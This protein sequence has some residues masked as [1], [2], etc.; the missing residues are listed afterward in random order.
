M[1]YSGWELNF[2]DNSKNF[3]NYQFFLIKKYLKNNLLEVG[4]GNG[5]MVDKYISKYFPN[6]TST[7]N[8]KNLNKTLVKK[9]KNKK[10]VKIYR[11]KI[12]EFKNKFN[13]II[14]SDVIE[15][16]KD[17]EKEI[18]IALKKLNKN[19]YLIIMVPAFQ[20][21]YSEYDKSIGHFR[22]YEKK[23]FVNF[24]KKNKIK[25]V[26]SI[27]FDSIGYFF[28]VLSKLINTKNKK[29]VGLGAF[30]WNLL[31]PISRILDVL[32]GYSFGKSVLCI[33]RKWE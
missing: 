18:K 15:H 4:P 33:Y 28:L 27:Y 13:S 7:N 23:F 9:F 19:G 10:N 26:K 22:R 30:V 16:I 29:N 20:Y 14:Y 1:R 25:C 21:L 12:G 6:I 32:I 17:D 24:A 5:I 2:F 8:Y 31:V 3:R 11:K